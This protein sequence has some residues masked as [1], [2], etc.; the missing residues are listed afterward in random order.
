L[1]VEACR[2]KDC[3]LVLKSLVVL[4]MFMG[5]MKMK[6]GGSLPRLIYTAHVKLLKIAT[7]F[8]TTGIGFNGNSSLEFKQECRRWS[9]AIDHKIWK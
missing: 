7:A 6:W 4:E 3:I 8:S 1:I 9:L 2:L 5:V